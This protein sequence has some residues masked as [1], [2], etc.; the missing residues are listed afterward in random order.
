MASAI[1]EG[2]SAMRPV[3]SEKGATTGK[4][5][6]T[7]QKGTATWFHKKI[8][9]EPPLRFDP[10]SG[11]K[12]QRSYTKREQ[13]AVVDYAVEMRGV[14][15]PEKC[16]KECGVPQPTLSRWIKNGCEAALKSAT[17]DPP[18]TGKIA[19]YREL[20]ADIRSGK[21]PIHLSDY[22]FTEGRSRSNRFGGKWVPA[23]EEPRGSCPYFL[24]EKKGTCREFSDEQKAKVVDYYFSEFDGKSVAECAVSCGVC[25]RSLY[26]WI[27]EGWG[28][29]SREERLPCF[30]ENHPPSGRSP[31]GECEPLRSVSVDDAAWLCPESFPVGPFGCPLQQGCRFPRGVDVVY[32][33]ALDD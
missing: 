4:K 28:R 8:R 24:P 2:Q 12:R 6:Y 27:D 7:R 23:R 18:Y 14:K 16:A 1:G 9:G 30:P 15:S 17:L 11:G 21:K 25:S 33:S 32:P 3:S 13:D 19:D 29:G 31:V 10:L 26:D 20:L 22:F 5:R